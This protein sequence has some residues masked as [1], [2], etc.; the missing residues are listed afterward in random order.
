MFSQWHVSFATPEQ[1]RS[2]A[3]GERGPSF[4]LEI[5]AECVFRAR[6][7]SGVLVVRDCRVHVVVAACVTPGV[8]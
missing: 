8:A 5:N 4:D 3:P 1:N 7:R 2:T 6:R